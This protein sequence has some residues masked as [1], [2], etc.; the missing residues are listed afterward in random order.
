MFNK[1]DA[2]NNPDDDEDMAEMEDDMEI[3]ESERKEVRSCE[4]RS[5][6][7]EHDICASNLAA[8]VAVD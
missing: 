7:Y 8:V 4:E 3:S 6:I 1:K 5:D 2:K